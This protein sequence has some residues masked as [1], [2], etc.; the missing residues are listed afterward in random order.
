MDNSVQKPGFGEIQ[1]VGNV[2]ASVVTL[3]EIR[4]SRLNFKI[5]R[6]D[7]STSAYICARLRNLVNVG[8]DATLTLSL[9]FVSQWHI[10]DK[11]NE[12]FYKLTDVNDDTRGDIVI[13]SDD[14]FGEVLCCKPCAKPSPELNISLIRAKKKSKALEKDPIF[15]LME[16]KL[17]AVDDDDDDE[18]RKLERE[19]LQ[20]LEELKIMI[21]NYVSKYH[22]YPTDELLELLKGKIVINPNGL[23][24]L[25]VN[26]NARIVLSDYDEMEIRMSARERMLYIFFLKHPE[27]VRQVDLDQHKKELMD[28]YS[29][30]FPGQN[31]E[32]A[33]TMIDNL[34]DPLNGAVRESISRIKKNVKDVIKSDEAQK[35][36]ISGNRG[37]VYKIELSRDMVQLPAAFT[38]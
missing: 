18:A 38:A 4:A 3:A 22:R 17:A 10:V 12:F 37:G 14:N 28:I 6:V 15:E 9:D 24:R 13:G 1:L 29:I 34:C 20:L 35:Y 2:P 5:T 11:C 21:L 23:S 19:R 32:R 27:G 31:D 16:Y 30:V 36:Y 8:T 26:G 33:T 7:D 25:V